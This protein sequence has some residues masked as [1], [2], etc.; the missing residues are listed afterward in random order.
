MQQGNAH[1]AEGQA[2]GEMVRFVQGIDHP[3]P[4]S[5]FPR[6]ARFLPPDRVIGKVPATPSNDLLLRLLIHFRHHVAEIAL[7]PGPKRAASTAIP[8]ARCR[9]SSM[10]HHGFPADSEQRG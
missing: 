8:Q 2:D 7:L 10:A 5:R 4:V 3:Q 9:T 6:P 1:G